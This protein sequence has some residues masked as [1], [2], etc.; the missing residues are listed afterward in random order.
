M[1][2]PSEQDMQEAILHLTM[3]VVSLRRELRELHKSETETA[4]LCLE[5]KYDNLI[6]EKEIARL[7][8]AAESPV[9]AV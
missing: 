6:L 2:E 7:K 5:A 4:G 8:K 9:T 1:Y 3:Q